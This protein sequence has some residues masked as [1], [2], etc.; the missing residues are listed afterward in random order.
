MRS[1]S[2]QSAFAFLLLAGLAGVGGLQHAPV[3]APFGV[4]QPATSGAT[5]RAEERRRP[6]RTEVPTRSSGP[7]STLT[8][9]EREYLLRRHYEEQGSIQR[10]Q[11]QQQFR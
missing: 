5:P 1:Y 11:L 3:T 10:Q 9:Y 4:W 8:P 2:T 7:R 6:D